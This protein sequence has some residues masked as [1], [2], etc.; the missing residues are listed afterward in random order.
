MYPLR[1]RS[2]RNHDQPYAFCDACKSENTNEG[3]SG[4]RLRVLYYE[5]IEVQLWVLWFVQAL[6]LSRSHRQVRCVRYWE[7]IALR[8]CYYVRRERKNLN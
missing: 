6:R 2:K 4:W 1:V 8:M 7:L 5:Y 3:G